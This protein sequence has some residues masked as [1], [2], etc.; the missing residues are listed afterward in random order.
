MK[1]FATLIK[2]ISRENKVEPKTMIMKRGILLIGLIGVFAACSNEAPLVEDQVQEQ[3][4]M[5]HVGDEGIEEVEGEQLGDIPPPPPPSIDD[6][7]TPI[8]DVEEEEEEIAEIAPPRGGGR[9]HFQTDPVATVERIFYLAQT[10]NLSELASLCDPQGQHDGDTKSICGIAN[11][12][13]SKQAEFMTMFR[14]GKVSGKPLVNNGKAAVPFLFGV[15]ATKSE[16]MNLV[17]RDGMWYLLS[18]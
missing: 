17:Q 13:K 1:I 18:F 16:T 2:Q 11:A 7:P 15:G 4:N 14:D 6:I 3:M 8:D 12:D 9:M 10:G 5:D